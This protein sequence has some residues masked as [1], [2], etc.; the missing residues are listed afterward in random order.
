MCFVCFFYRNILCLKEIFV[1][2][3]STAVPLAW[4][5]ISSLDTTGIAKQE[6]SFLGPLD[7]CEMQALYSE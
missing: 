5:C 7:G 6:V 4:Q 2:C 1:L 3:P